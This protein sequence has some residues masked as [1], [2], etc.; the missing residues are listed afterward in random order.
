MLA[1]NHHIYIR[2]DFDFYLQPHSAMKGHV[3]YTHY[4]VIHDE[5]SFTA[6]EIQQGIHTAS[7]LYGRATKA[8]SLIPAAYY[9]DLA[10]ERA[11]CYL[12]NLF[13]GH[14]NPTGG[15]KNKEAEAMRVF[16]DATKA[17]GN[18]VSNYT[19]RFLRSFKLTYTRRCIGT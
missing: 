14:D 6:D 4:V 18:G 7:Y 3:K 13:V 10:C 2:F 19:N 11:R 5:I 15:C 12:N 9:A 8:V 1:H 17:W 16:D